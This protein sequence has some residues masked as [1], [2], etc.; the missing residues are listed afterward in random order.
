M[1]TQL[2]TLQYVGVALMILGMVI[3]GLVQT[4]FVQQMFLPETASDLKKA[5]LE[6]TALQIFTAPLGIIG[7]IVYKI[8]QKKKD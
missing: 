5:E 8:G 3:W 2:N 7:L 6:S 4:E 1:P